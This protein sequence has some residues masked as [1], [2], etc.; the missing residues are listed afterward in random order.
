M[1]IPHYVMQTMKIPKTICTKMDR[2]C[3]QFICGSSENNKKVHLINW[4]KICSSK[5]EGGLGFRKARKVN[6]AC[7]M[8]LA[9]GVL[10]NP[11]RLWVKVMRAKYNYGEDILP[12]HKGRRNTS[13]AWKGIV[14]VQPKFKQNLVWR[15]DDGENVKIWLDHWIPGVYKL[16]EFSAIDLEGEVQNQKAYLREQELGLE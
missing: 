8:K 7:L 6:L 16:G 4:D 11:E 2:I 10:T 5:D 3:K 1:S 12:N 13:N 15:L 14:Q 9:W